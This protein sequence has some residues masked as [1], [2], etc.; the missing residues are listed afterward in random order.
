MKTIAHVALAICL[1]ILV[2]GA[3][4]CLAIDAN[5]ASAQA[6]L[7]PDGV[8][9][10]PGGV[11]ISNSDSLNNFNFNNSAAF[12]TP[13]IRDRT[14]ATVAPQWN[15]SARPGLDPTLSEY[16]TPI[17]EPV[18][19]T[20]PLQKWRLGIYP[21][22]TDTGVRV[23]E[24]VRGSA[25]ERVGLEVNDRLVS[26]GGYQVGYVGGTLYDIGAEFERHADANGWVRVLVQNN[27]DGKLMNL[28]LQLDSRHE[29]STGVIS[30][31]LVVEDTAGGGCTTFLAAPQPRKPQSPAGA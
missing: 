1:S 21:E 7:S 31:V 15:D 28:P 10:S 27:R 29:S 22:D 16:W 30:R 2:L 11:G 25:A 5:R 4:V 6:Q 14:S 3:D 20:T 17:P 23:A 24:V 26:I 19:Q 12:T 8:G 18:A 9:L 13:A